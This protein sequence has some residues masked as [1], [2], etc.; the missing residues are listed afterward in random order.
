MFEPK[1][2]KYQPDGEQKLCYLLIQLMCTNQYSLKSEYLKKVIHALLAMLKEL[3]EEFFGIENII[4]NCSLITEQ[5]R[6]QNCSGY[7]FLHELISLLQ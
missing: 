3:I 2:L 5:V 6:K 1:V 7:L 4:G